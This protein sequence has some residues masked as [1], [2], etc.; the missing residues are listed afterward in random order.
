MI[1]IKPIDGFQKYFI[2]STGKVLSPKGFLKNQKAKDGYLAVG[3][4]NENGFKRKPVHRLV[5]EAFIPNVDNKPQVNHINGV[6]T[7]N[8][9]ENLEWCTEYENLKHAVET[10]LRDL[11]GERNGN[12][13]LNESEVIQIKRMLEKGDVQVCK[14]AEMYKVLPSAI[15]KI[16]VGRTWRHL[17]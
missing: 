16:K 10:G 11:R 13:K 3:L 8:R 15:S 9:V 7:D 17:K 6:K 5:A 1:N 14:I 4:Y 12:H 2:C